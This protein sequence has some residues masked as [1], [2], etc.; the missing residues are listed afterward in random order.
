MAINYSWTV[1]DMY[2]M[3]TP[4]PDYVSMIR[5][6]VEAT[7]DTSNTTV[8]INRMTDFRVDANQTSF[9]AYSDLTPQIVLGWIQEDT[10]Q[11]QAIEGALQDQINRIV[12]PPITPTNT[13]L[14]WI[15]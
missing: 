7:D 6:N 14:P 10:Q 5:Y 11:V 13:T 1:T 2:T 15:K 4:T 9:I 8:S 3:P 12:N